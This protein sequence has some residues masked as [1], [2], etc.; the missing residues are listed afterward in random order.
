MP[1]EEIFQHLQLLSRLI[2][3]LHTRVTNNT[4]TSVLKYQ[5]QVRLRIHDE[6]QSPAQHKVIA[7]RKLRSKQFTPA[8]G[9]TNSKTYTGR[10]KTEDTSFRPAVRRH[11]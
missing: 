8:H 5:H 4:E 6:I 3:D 2:Q 1:S 9:P 11:N 7:R 10:L